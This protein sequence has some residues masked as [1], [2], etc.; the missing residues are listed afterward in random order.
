MTKAKFIAVRVRH[1]LI[2]PQHLGAKPLCTNDKCEDMQIMYYQSWNEVSESLTWVWCA[3]IADN[4]SQ[5]DAKGPD[6]RFYGERAVVDGLRGCPFY[7]EFGSWLM[8]KI[9]KFELVLTLLLRQWLEVSCCCHMLSN[10][11]TLCSF[12]QPHNN[13]L[14]S[15]LTTFVL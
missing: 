9:A 12:S 15:S 3:S 1:G 11:S 8:G 4:L 5:Q 6:I 10:T 13:S 7:G 14:S 2:G